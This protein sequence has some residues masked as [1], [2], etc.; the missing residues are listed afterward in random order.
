MGNRLFRK[1][2]RKFRVLKL[3][4]LYCLET[5]LLIA[6]IFQVE[7]LQI[8]MPQGLTSEV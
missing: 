6:E 1:L 2:S 4:V 3:F 7:S 8:E 5:K